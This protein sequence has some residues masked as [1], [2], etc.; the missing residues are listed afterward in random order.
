ML[1][2]EPHPLALLAEMSYKQVKTAVWR[3]RSPEYENEHD[4]GKVCWLWSFKH[5][6]SQ[7]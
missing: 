6:L 1:S 4:L 7:S 3:Q 2:L 5:L